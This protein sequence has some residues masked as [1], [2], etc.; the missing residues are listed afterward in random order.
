MPDLDLY[1]EKCPECNH[2]QKPTVLSSNKGPRGNHQ[3]YKATYRCQNDECQNAWMKD[4][5]NKDNE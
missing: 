2:N 1:K 4:F 5:G 3:G